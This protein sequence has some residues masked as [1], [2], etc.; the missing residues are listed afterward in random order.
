MKIKMATKNEVK[1]GELRQA[2]EAMLQEKN[3]ISSLEF[4]VQPEIPTL[5]FAY[6]NMLSNQVRI[7]VRPEFYDVLD[8]LRYKHAMKDST[9]EL[10]CD[11]LY[12]LISHEEG[13]ARHCPATEKGA[14]EILKGIREGVILHEW[15]PI[16]VMAKTQRI[17]N[18]F[19]D[20]IANTILS[21][22][23]KDAE[24]F[25][26]GMLWS[27]LSNFEFSKKDKSI[28]ERT[29]KSFNLFMDTNLYLWNGESY[30]TYVN[31]SFLD[32]YMLGYKRMRKKLLNVIL[33][34]DKDL[35]D[36]VLD[37][38]IDDKTSR[39]ICDEVAKMPAWKAKAREYAKILAPLDIYQLVKQKDDQ[40]EN[41]DE[42][43][44]GQGNTPTGDNNNNRRP[45][46]K[47]PEKRKYSKVRDVN[48]FVYSFEEL[49]R[50]YREAA[51]R[52]ELDVECAGLAFS[53]YVGSEETSLEDID[54]NRVDWSS[55]RLAKQPNGQ[56][57]IELFQKVYPITLRIAQN[58][59]KT[60]AIPD[61]NFILDRSGSMNFIPFDNSSP[62]HLALLGFYGTLNTIESLGLQYLLNY[63]V[64]VFSD[65]TESSDWQRFD[66]LDEA[67]QKAFK[68]GG[69]DTV[70][71]INDLK[72]VHDTRRDNY[73]S[74]MLTDGGLVNSTQV[75]DTIAP[76]LEDGCDKFVLFKIGEEDNF[77]SAMRGIGADVNLIESAADFIKKSIK[78][79]R[80]GLGGSG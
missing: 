11:S 34:E 37:C 60:G 63:N 25:K 52:I 48:N 68:F 29:E 49:D 47:K 3:L 5:S 10:A 23:D 76:M 80:D 40:Q 21:Y 16:M 62:Y 17:S 36:A 7:G 78:T 13:H 46:S 6:I 70:L 44:G 71:E 39:K 61:L 28:F 67:K 73:M 14:Q 8:H 38:N 33:G 75:V 50:K 31:R 45:D 2:C 57:Y 32:K 74:I 58:Y 51:K 79:T 59:K 1:I 24:R 77:S 72:K 4:T 65:K 43:D 26:H 55:I 41:Q 54:F 64:T 20:T 53:K 66:G 22:E 9:K 56:P 15:K 30:L 12:G 69:S 27:Y 42:E 18:M 35:C 19:M